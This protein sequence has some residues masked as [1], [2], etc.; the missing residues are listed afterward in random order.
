LRKHGGKH[1]AEGIEEIADCRFKK[2][3]RKKLDAKG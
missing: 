3:G 1:R 2:A